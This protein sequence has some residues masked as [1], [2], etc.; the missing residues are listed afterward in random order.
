MTYNKD[1]P[2]N[3]LPTIPPQRNLETIPI[4]KKADGC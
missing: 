3:T 1:I 2:Y 4:L